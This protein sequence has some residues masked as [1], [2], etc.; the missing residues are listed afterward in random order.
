MVLLAGI[1]ERHDSAVRKTL[2]FA[3]IRDAAEFTLLH[4]LSAHVRF[5]R[6]HLLACLSRSVHHGAQSG[7][8]P[9][10]YCPLARSAS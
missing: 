5:S 1:V 3:I 9:A 7:K 2:E 10:W 8:A 4:A 6:G